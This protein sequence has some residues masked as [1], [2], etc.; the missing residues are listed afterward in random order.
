MRWVLPEIDRE[1][2]RRLSRELGVSPLLGRM[3]VLR[4]YSDPEQAD[5]FLHPRLAHLHDPFRIRGMDA[6][7]GRILEAIRRRERILIYGDYDV[8]GTMAVVVLQAALRQV[9]CEVLHYIPH[10]LRDGYGM[11]EEVVEQARE[12]GIS[13]IISVDTGIRA[14]AVVERARELGLDCIITDHHLPVRPGPEASGVPRAV[15][16]LNPKQPNCSYPDKNLCGAGVAFKLAQ[17]VLVAQGLEAAQVAR[18]LASF[19]KLVSIGTIADSVPLVGENRVIARLGLEGL[20]RPVNA[21]LKALLEAA[22]LSGKAVSAWDVAFR[23]APRLNAA[24]RMESAQQVIELFS[25]TDSDRAQEL[26]LKLNRLNAERQ[27]AEQQILAEIDERHR[28][29]PEDF[30]RGFLVLAGEGWHRGVLGIVASRLVDRFQRP[31]LVIA[32]EQGTGHGSGRSA[33]N[34]HLLDALTA[35]EDLFDR[36]GGHAQAAGFALP[37]DRIAELRRRLN[38][39]AAGDLRAEDGGPGIEVDAEVSFADLSPALFEELEQLAPFGSGNPRP[40]FLAR[41]VRVLGRPRLLQEKHL[42]MQVVEQACSLDAVGWRKANWLER[43][44]VADASLDLAF[45]LGL[46]HY[47]NQAR[48]QLELLDLDCRARP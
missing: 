25:V 43:L 11:R 48:L 17:A 47:Q 34:F 44:N 23:L 29:Q 2:A 40:V 14:F 8:D 19:L 27:N 5:R 24:G 1:A 42:K 35:C 16:V 39:Y 3:L 32:L 12:Q 41:D 28:R 37:T 46:N 38:E 7:V 26:A 6:A 20:S 36:F 18:M 31:T 33:G 30:S 22:G 9:G 10:R 15:A 13:L 4:G 21:G 45:H